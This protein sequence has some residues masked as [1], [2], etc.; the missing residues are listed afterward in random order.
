MV[1]EAVDADAPASSNIIALKVISKQYLEF[2]EQLQREIDILKRISHPH[3][4][5]LHEHFET[6]DSHYLSFDL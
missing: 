5:N 3:V 6:P 1:Y 2:P 4:V